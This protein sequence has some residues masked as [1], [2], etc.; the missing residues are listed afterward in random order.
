MSA[1]FILFLISHGSALRNIFLD[2]AKYARRWQET[3]YLKHLPMVNLKIVDTINVTQGKFFT[4]PGNPNHKSNH[5]D[6]FF[7][8]WYMFA[9]FGHCLSIARLGG[10][11]LLG[12]GGKYVCNPHRINSPCILFSMG[13]NEDISFETQ[14]L[15]NVAKC[16]IFAF[17][18]AEHVAKNFTIW[19][20]Q[21]KYS[22]SN[23]EFHK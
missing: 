23:Y 12:D 3:F 15:D 10:T 19:Y 5:M 4:I 8:I 11:N 9:D 21:S 20:R 1:F 14:F 22:K 2:E 17:D 18:P 6:D 7:G 13:I 16:D